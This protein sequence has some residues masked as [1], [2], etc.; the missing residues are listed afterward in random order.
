MRPA[1]QQRDL[2]QIGGQALIEVLQTLL[3]LP[4]SAVSQASG[5]AAPDHLLIL[6]TVILTGRQASGAVRLQVTEEFATHAASILFGENRANTD[7]QAEVDDLVG[8]LCNM[9]AGRVAVSLGQEGQPCTLGTP[10]ITRGS[11]LPPESEAGQDWGRTHWTCHQNRITLEV[12]FHT[13][14]S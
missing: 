1:S 3:S 7:F 14:P 2:R 10:V 6:G 5:D 4:E 8:E 13:R 12:R 9:V 11:R